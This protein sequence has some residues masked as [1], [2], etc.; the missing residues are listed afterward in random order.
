MRQPADH[1]AAMQAVGAPNI[2]LARLV[3]CRLWLPAAPLKAE[4]SRHGDRIDE[5]RVVFFEPGR[6]AVPA[7]HLIEMRLAVG[8][9]VTQRRVGPANEDGKVAAL[10]PGAGAQG[11]AL[12]SLDRQIAS[13]E[14]HEE[15]RCRVQRPEKTG[16]AF[17]RAPKN[18]ALDSLALR[19]TLI[20]RND[21]EG[22]Q[23]TSPWASAMGSLT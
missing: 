17:P 5:D 14:V 12:P 22:H 6:I 23:R 4:P 1:L 15:R 10:F 21:R 7:A 9:V 18:A 13:F 2:G 3:G 8:L 11:V 19:E 16:L 20:C